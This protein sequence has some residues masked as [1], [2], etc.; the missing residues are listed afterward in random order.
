MPIFWVFL[1]YLFVFHYVPKSLFCYFNASEFMLNRKSCGSNS[2]FLYFIFSVSFL[3]H[4]LFSL[5]FFFSYSSSCVIFIFAKIVQKETNCSNLTDSI[6]L[7]LFI[8]FLFIFNSMTEICLGQ[9]NCILQYERIIEICI[10][11]TKTVSDMSD[12]QND[13]NW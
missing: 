5:Y 9:R 7:F 2:S 6:P 11:K 12:T 13:Q 8:Y 3:P 10:Y 4:F 1:F